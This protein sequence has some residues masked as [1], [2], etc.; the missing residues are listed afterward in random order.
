MKH[1]LIT[2][3]F[4][5][6]GLLNLSAQHLHF[7]TWSALNR[8]MYDLSKYSN[9]GSFVTYGGRIAFGHQN[10]QIG[11]EYESNLTNP[12]FDISDD[13]GNIAQR[14]DFDYTY[15]GAL[16]RINSAKIP[17]YRTGLILKLGGGL[18]DSKLNISEMPNNKLIESVD[19]PENFLGINGGIGLSSP[20]Y[21]VIHWEIFYQFN[22]AKIPELE[23]TASINPEFTAIHH[24]LQVGV[25]L[26]FVFGEAARRAKEV[27]KA[28]G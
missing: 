17:A 28:K 3:L 19:Y 1:F 4:F 10:F 5:L 2:G 9:N 11:A 12:I 15:Y 21:K 26:N 24:S 6:F 16:F 20:L 14:E 18:Y 13:D 22:Y 23:T 7:A 27:L 25:S 8:T